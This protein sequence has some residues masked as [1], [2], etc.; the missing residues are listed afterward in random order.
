MKSKAIFIAA[1]GQN[2]G[3]TTLCL[4]LIASLK[5][6]FD[7]VGFI[8]PVGQ[9]HVKVENETNVDKDA[10][11]FKE[12]FHLQTRWA[13]M[14]PVIIPAGFTREYLDGKV[15]EESMLNKI[16]QSFHQI[17]QQNQY[18]VVEGTGHVGVG[19]IV[20]VNNARIASLL[21]LEM[22][23]I[24]AGGL[25][26]A[27]DELALNVAL[28]KA[29]GVTVRGI[30]LNKVLPDKRN[31]ILEYFPK[32]LKE[33]GIPL[34]G[35]IP[36][37][38]FLSNPTIKDFEN[39]FGASLISGEKQR[40]RHFQQ[41]R[42]V[43]GSLNAY[44]DD[45]HPNELVITPASREDII[46]AILEHQISAQKKGEDFGCGVILTSR[47]PPSRQLLERIRQVDIPVLYAPVCSYDAMKLITSFNAKIRWEDTPRVEQAIKTFEEHLD[48]DALCG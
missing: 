42:L 31:M 5:K 38:P 40:Y 3:K 36:F 13:D 20:N 8:K 6:R 21:G 41:T 37:N 44:K 10:V 15:S 46:D 34:I 26:S 22:V 25:G 45:I 14:S 27:F 28:C 9:Q 23:I 24:A 19:S 18:T 30:I 7:S 39:L 4:G 47:H 33:W 1:T 29:Q 12:H 35:C 48:I 2:V 17:A 16:K 11:L 43:A 32:A